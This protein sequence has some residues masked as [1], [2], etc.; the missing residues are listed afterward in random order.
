MLG[1]GPARLRGAAI[2]I[3]MLALSAGAIGKQQ[4]PAAQAP[5]P[6]AAAPPAGPPPNPNAAA[7]AEDH[8]NMMEQLGIKALRP[9]PSGNE[10][11]PNHANYDE[12]IA[13]PYPTLP[14][15]LT[16][17]NGRKVTTA[18]MWWKQRRPEIVEDFDREVVGRV[19][20]TVPKVTWR[21]NR[22]EKFEVGG[23]PV[24]GKELVGAVDNSAYPDITVEIQMTVVTPANAARPVPVMMM[25][26][27]RSGMPPA[28]GTPPPA[29]RGFGPGRG[30]AGGPGGAP[31]GPQDPPATEQLIAGGWGYATI[32]P[33]SIQ[34]DN[35]AGL[36][37]GI[38]GL[39]NKGQRRKPEDW[40][41]LR[42][43]AWGASRGLDY[44]ETDAA[45]DAKK[46][47]IEGVSRFGKAALVT[48]AYDQR[49]AV[50]LIGSSGK[51][52]ATLLRRNFG[53]AVENLT[54]S[55]EYHWMAGN[56][57]KY[58][59]EESTFGRKTAADLPVDAHELL[60]LC[61]PRLTFLSYGIPERG[62]AR[63]LDHQGSYMAA[64]A[65]QPVFRLL[66][67]KALG[68]SDDYMKEK[69]PA[70]NVDVLDGQLAWRQHDGGHTDGPNWKHFIP[71]ADRFLKHSSS[72]RRDT[73]AD[74]RADRP[75]PRTDQNSMTAH[76]QLRDKAKQGRIDVYFAGDSIVRRW[77]ALDYPDLLANWK[78]NFFGW[79]AANFGWGADRTQNILW[80]LEN[81]ELDG[82]NP[83][84]IVLLAG[85]NNVGA[86]PRGDDTIAEIASGVKAIVDLCRRKAPDAT[87]VLTAIFPRND[88]IAVMPTI[89]RINEKIAT[90]ADGKR[91]RFLNI[92]DRL[93]SPDGTLVDGVMNERD[94]L[95]PTL[96]GY[97]I[98]AD[99]LKPILHELLGPPAATD[100][101]PP[102]TGDPSAARRMP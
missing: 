101:A 68:V 45:V 32:N 85:T 8:R 56:F 28:P 58:G 93:A 34:A 71:W 4:P 86:Q 88:N 54:G 17:K 78:Q 31:A 7:T 100:L 97:Q 6:A 38:I 55:G 60:A 40:G 29:A 59:T 25:F 36:T 41:S 51:G 43:W 98:W 52:G 2:A 19:P 96:E 48:M 69:M 3:L 27:G 77:G 84:V 35:G 99:A 15:P 90:F 21:V 92:N 24:I 64:V 57:L 75:A 18:E 39:V 65:A 49:F 74:A 89:A 63:W 72:V 16:A 81:G 13:D 42:A 14:D 83:K 87:I 76:A 82:V 11:A 95:H 53:E 12:T 73:P 61:A 26:G 47:G 22:T 30:G 80:R 50:V 91:V 70:V 10:S 44:L 67:A 94:K 102:P 33:G 5:P 1:A 66:G 62:D 9:G 23:R 20:R 46:V 79:N 37:K